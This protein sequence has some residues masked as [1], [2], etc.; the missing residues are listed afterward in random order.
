MSVVTLARSYYSDVC[1]KSVMLAGGDWMPAVGESLPRD[2]GVPPCGWL[3]ARGPTGSC[4]WG[5]SN[6]GSSV[7]GWEAPGN[8][9][10]IRFYSESPRLRCALGMV[11]FASLGLVFTEETPVTSG[12]GRRGC[13]CLGSFAPWALARSVFGARRCSL[14]RRLLSC[15]WLCSHT[16]FMLYVEQFMVWG[17]AHNPSTG[18][19]TVFELANEFRKGDTVAWVGE[20]RIDHIGDTTASNTVTAIHQEADAVIV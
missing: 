5:E 9:E 1:Q 19:A 20:Y 13:D 6:G 17:D 4:G 3:A 8:F 12:M 11:S 18:Y 15:E 2:S 16:G 14:S 10:G 7:P